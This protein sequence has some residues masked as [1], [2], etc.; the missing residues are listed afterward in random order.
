MPGGSTRCLL[1]CQLIWITYFTS[2]WNKYS[3]CSWNG[4]KVLYKTRQLTFQNSFVSALPYLAMWLFSIACSTIADLLIAKQVFKVVTVRK[5]FNSIGW[6]CC[7]LEE[8]A[9]LTWFEFEGQY[10]PALA[11]I[12]AGFIGCN[13]V[14]AV[15]LLTLAV[16]LSGASYSGFQV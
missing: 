2:T 14:A 12:G 15:V 5:I 16:G 1:S 13:T 10:G 9:Y 4:W 8:F 6:A 7:F 11:L 3:L